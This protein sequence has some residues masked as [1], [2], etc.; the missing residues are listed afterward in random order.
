MTEVVDKVL[1]ALRGNNLDKKIDALAKLEEELIEET[2][3]EPQEINQLIPL[4][5]DAVKGSQV[6][7]SNAALTCLNPF[8]SLIAE[9]HPSQFKNVVLAFATV[10]VDK[11]GDSK[12]KTRD[13]ALQ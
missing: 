2:P 13:T 9:T 3:L 8:V 6:A 7:L 10:V 1:E 4:L 5:K 11:Q 12:D